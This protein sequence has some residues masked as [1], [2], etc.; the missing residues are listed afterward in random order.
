MK[1]SFFLTFECQYLKKFE[2]P[3]F[4]NHIIETY[5]TY[6]KE[7]ICQNVFQNH[8]LSADSIDGTTTL[9]T[10]QNEQT[11]PRYNWS[12]LLSL[13]NKIKD[14]IDNTNKYDIVVYI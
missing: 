1:V 13:S 5:F 7:I 10:W 6:Y 11:R 8:F 9:S 12:H 3:G 4:T 2:Y 14:E